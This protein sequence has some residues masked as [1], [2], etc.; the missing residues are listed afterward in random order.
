MPGL[1]GDQARREESMWYMRDG[2]NKSKEG[3]EKAIDELNDS[4]WLT[5]WRKQMFRI[6]YLLR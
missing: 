1:I 5:R 2:H 3:I 6:H 4:R